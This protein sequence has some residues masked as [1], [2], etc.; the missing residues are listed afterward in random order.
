MTT[1]FEKALKS[2]FFLAILVTVLF[3]TSLA[4]AAGKQKI[5]FL[6][7]STGG[8]LYTQGKVA[9]WFDSYNSQN[10]TSYSISM[11]AYPD[12][13]YNWKNY[14][15]DYWNLWINPGGPAMSGSSGVDTLENLARNY[16]VIVW[17]HC[18]PGAGIQPD[19]GSPSVSSS[20][21]TPANYKLQYRALRAKF[22]TM[23][24]TIFI[25][26]TLAP[27]HRLATTSANASRA[28]AFVDWVRNDWLTEDSKKHPN[29]F[30][31]D[32]WKNAA[33]DHRNP[34]HANAKVNTLRYEYE[35]SHSSSDS[36]PNSLANRTIGPLF[37]QRI[38]DVIESFDANT[39]GNNETETDSATTL[40]PP[41]NLRIISQ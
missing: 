41:T 24:D 7:H 37:A 38:V 25:V 5:I 32:F 1:Y 22:D 31:F 6:R 34:S 10:D 20:T 9:Q 26:W 23:P 8:N 18:F 33:E 4:F 3:S 35:G 15:Y 17:K 14:P 36:H 21:K 16:D 29:I 30:I 19:S 13:P 28:R 2:G 11:R 27:L 39:P 40:S 12:K